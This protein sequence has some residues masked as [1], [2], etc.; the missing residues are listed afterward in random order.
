MKKVYY[1]PFVPSADVDYF[2]LFSLWDIAEYS[3]NKQPDTIQYH[4]ISR[5]AVRL[6]C[7]ASC[8]NTKIAKDAYKC[9]IT[10]DKQAKTI[11]L[12]NN[13][14]KGKEKRLFVRLSANE[15]A[16]LR[17]IG[18][19]L[20]CKYYLYLKYYCEVAEKKN[21][22]QDFTANQFLSAIGYSV[23]SNSI[24][25]KLGYYNTLL[26]QNGFIKI[27]VY[28]DDAGRRRNAFSLCSLSVNL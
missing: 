22:R 3:V 1:I 4:S 25:N 21:I 11:T 18:D 15:V 9:F 10:I 13:F 12:L 2:F 16:F 8:I 17:S 19:N 24:K 23:K 5:L 14:Q 6:G 20:L 28:R 27:S 26:Q 7:S